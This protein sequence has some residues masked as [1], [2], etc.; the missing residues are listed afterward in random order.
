MS[1]LRD[2]KR[3]IRANRRAIKS[4]MPVTFDLLAMR[5]PF[6]AS[7]MAGGLTYS[8][9][10]AVERGQ[11]PTAQIRAV[12]IAAR[13]AALH[14]LPIAPMVIMNEWKK[15][16]E[17]DAKYRKAREEAQRLADTS[18]QDYGIEANDYAKKYFVKPL[19]PIQYRFGHEL[20]IEVVSPMDPAKCKP[21]HGQMARRV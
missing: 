21:G 9:A 10:I 3:R 16:P 4:R 20:R 7:A 18:G 13:K 11:A 1:L 6:I 8:Q 19:P 12:G 2:M 15:T 5:R 17:G 14:A